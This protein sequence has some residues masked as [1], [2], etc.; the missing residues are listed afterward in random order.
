MNRSVAGDIDS[1]TD[2]LYADSPRFGTLN[3]HILFPKMLHLSMS[4]SQGVTWYWTYSQYLRKGIFY[5]EQLMQKAISSMYYSL[6]TIS[7]IILCG[8]AR[9]F[10]Y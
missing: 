4:N 10:L 6:P 2:T 9:V 8:L 1:P 3:T 7:V 5:N